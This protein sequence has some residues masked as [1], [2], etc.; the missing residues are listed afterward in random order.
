[1][2]EAQRKEAQAPPPDKVRGHNGSDSRS[3]LTK[4]FSMRHY[5]IDA[6]LHL[7]QQSQHRVKGNTA[8]TLRCTSSDLL[9]FQ[10]P[11]IFHFPLLANLLR[12][13]TFSGVLN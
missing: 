1:M 5:H 6:R 8:A 7:M 3:L 11:P 2:T 4:G 13:T 12:A 10:P 9:N